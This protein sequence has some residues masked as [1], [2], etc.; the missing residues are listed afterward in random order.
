MCG[1]CP[2]KYTTCTSKKYEAQAPLC[3]LHQLED[4]IPLFYDFMS[5]YR[6][7]RS[8]LNVKMRTKKWGFAGFLRLFAIF[9]LVNRAICN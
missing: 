5:V 3:Y 1:T 4:Y 6:H 8:R 2:K 9:T 7:L